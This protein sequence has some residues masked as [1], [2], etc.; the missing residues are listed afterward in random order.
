MTTR[1]QLLGDLQAAID[2]GFSGEIEASLV[3]LIEFSTGG[4]PSA[5]S[6]AGL[7]L[8]T[9]T[10]VLARLDATSKWFYPVYREVIK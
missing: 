1:K 4:T 6:D 5:V 3:A 9:L 7:D 2:D 8:A 10:A